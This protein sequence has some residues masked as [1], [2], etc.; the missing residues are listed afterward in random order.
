M[1]DIPID[2]EVAIVGGGL[3]G[4]SAALMLGRAHV[5]TCVIDDASAQLYSGETHNFITNDGR[6]KADVLRAAGADI[7]GYPSI[8]RRDDRVLSVVKDALSYELETEAG[9]TITARRLVIATGFP[10]FRDNCGIEGLRT[11]FGRTVFTCPFC[12]GYEFTGARIALIG[13]GE[14]DG[15]FLGT[16]A[17]WSP[18]INY[19]THDAAQ[20][21]EAA[22]TLGQVSDGSFVEGRIV[23]LD[24]DGAQGVATLEDGRQIAADAF[25]AADLP[26]SLS[27]PLA[28]SLEIERS[29][30]PMTGRAIYKT[31][32]T[33]RTDLG[34]AFILGDIRTGFSTLTGAANEGMVAGFMLVNDIVAARL[35]RAGGSADRAA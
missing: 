31:D 7:A 30:H 22:R 20:T 1:Y 14:A 35:G 11:Q 17:N 21:E 24:N 26:V 15:Q 27:S 29:L 16:L 6:T 9:E 3:S 18:H 5:S 8:E 34:D 12:H 23:R 19:I 13:G 32:A 25:F 10:D 33:G 4:L 2:F 28:D